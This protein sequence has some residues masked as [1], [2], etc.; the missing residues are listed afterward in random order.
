[1]ILLLAVIITTVVIF[2]WLTSFLRSTART[3]VA[4]AAIVLILFLLIGIQPSTLW[5]Q[6][7]VF[8][9]EFWALVLGN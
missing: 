5:Q 3:I 6:V 9:R 8:W 7:Q 4:I 1:M 2:S